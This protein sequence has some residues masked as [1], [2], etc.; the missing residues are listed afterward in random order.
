ME[1]EMSRIKITAIVT[2]VLGSLPANGSSQALPWVAPES[3]GI[4]AERLS[5]V[6]ALFE[7]YI[8]DG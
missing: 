3:V 1:R 5:R 2:F 8:A 4:S 6:D 7:S